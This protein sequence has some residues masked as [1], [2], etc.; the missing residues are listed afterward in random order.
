MPNPPMSRQENEEE[1]WTS[2]DVRQAIRQQAQIVDLAT[3]AFG[4]RVE[5][6]LDGLDSEKLDEKVRADIAYN[7]AAKLLKL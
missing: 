2:V 5:G 7:N 1:A 3:D 6:V 4:P